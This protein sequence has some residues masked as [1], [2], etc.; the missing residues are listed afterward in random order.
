MDGMLS[1][2]TPEQ[3]DELVAYDRVEPI[4]DEKIC[5][6]LASVGAAIVNRLNLLA[7]SWGNKDLREAKPRH[8][9]PWAAK[10][11]RKQAQ[12]EKYTSPQNMALAFSLVAGRP[13][14]GPG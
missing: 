1:E 11:M 3:F 14:N 6:V 5:W 12:K 10:R 4:G 7:A 9:I 8:F 2:M 13:H